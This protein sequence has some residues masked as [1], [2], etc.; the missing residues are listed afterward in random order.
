MDYPPVQ[1]KKLKDQ[2]RFIAELLTQQN[3]AKSVRINK[4]KIRKN[5]DRQEDKINS[6]LY[7]ELE[8]KSWKVLTNKTDKYM[9]VSIAN[10]HITL[11]IEP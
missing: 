8:R 7:L 2:L 5:L 10:N 3:S 11:K 1:G 4:I 9:N 6:I